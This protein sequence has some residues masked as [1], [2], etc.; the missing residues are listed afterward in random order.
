MSRLSRKC[1]S[2]DVSQPNGPPRPVTRIALT[3]LF[4]YLILFQIR[5]EEGGSMYLRNVSTFLPNHILT[6]VNPG[7]SVS[8]LVSPVLERV[9]T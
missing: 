3:Y 6:A 9:F 1:G 7:S 2:L 8:F 5:S 4:T